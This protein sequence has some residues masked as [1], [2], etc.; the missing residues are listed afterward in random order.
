MLLHKDLPKIIS[1]SVL[2]N[3]IE[4]EVEGILEK[5]ELPK[6]EPHA[7]IVFTGRDESSQIL[8]VVGELK[9]FNPVKVG[10]PNPFTNMKIRGRLVEFNL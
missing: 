4:L 10:M 2:R 3:I 6:D 7:Y 8:I 5:P 1:I 9:I